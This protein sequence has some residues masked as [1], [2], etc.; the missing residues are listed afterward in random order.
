MRHAIMSLWLGIRD[1]KQ[2]R[3]ASLRAL[4]AIV[5]LLP[6]IAACLNDAGPT[7]SDSPSPT[8]RPTVAPTGTAEAVASPEPTSS[9]TPTAS[10]RRPYP[11]PPVLTSGCTQAGVLG[12]PTPADVG[13]EPTPI[14]DSI[15]ECGGSYPKSAPAHLGVIYGGLHGY[16][17]YFAFIEW[18]PDGERLML[19]VPREGEI[20]G[21]G[22]YLVSTDGSGSRL[23]VDASPEHNMLAGF[24]GDLSPDG[25]TLVYSTC[26]QRV[27]GGYRDYQIATLSVEEGS[28]RLL[29][30]TPR[31]DNYPVWSPDG[32]RIAFL[33]SEPWY[34][35]ENSSIARLYTIEANGKLRGLTPHLN[36]LYYASPEPPTWSPDGE[37]LAYVQ[38]SSAYDR[39]LF[40]VG[41]DGSDLHGVTAVTTGASW[42]PEGRRIAFGKALPRN[43]PD[44][45]Y[46]T[47][48][49]A[50]LDE[51][52]RPRLSQIIPGDTFQGPVEIM[53]VHWSPDGNEI[54]FMVGERGFVYNDDLG[55]YVSPD[56]P[57]TTSVYLVRPDG[58]G[59]RR[60]LED[61]RPYTAAAWSPDG[62]RIAIRVDPQLGYVHRGDPRFLYLEQ[63][64]PQFEILIVDRDGSV[65]TALGRE[66]ILGTN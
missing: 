58:T 61:E 36:W 19:N 12:D 13:P 14:G 60:L 33:I 44:D 55:V 40:T 22:I 54:L 59:L 63:V 28:P 2:A 37:R 46:S 34:Y 27:H 18:T 42:A 52:G 30:D 8:S 49:M 3:P 39:R 62:S 31:I 45:P 65:Q 41:E 16:S 5:L 53:Y 10:Y 23:L 1:F 64:E 47:L 6:S 29:T 48:C 4:L 57:V 9:P 50:E 26:A 21:T 25:S 17:N 20:V 35:S 38:E 15:G 43:S 7:A 24:H 66:E 51:L 32:S 56:V 11:T